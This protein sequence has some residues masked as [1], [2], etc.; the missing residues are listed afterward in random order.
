M[1][2]KLQIQKKRCSE[3]RSEHLNV[4]NS[5]LAFVSC[6]SCRQIYTTLSILIHVPQCAFLQKNGS[7]IRKRMIF[8][9]DRNFYSSPV[10]TR[11]GKH[12][13]HLSNSQKDHS[14]FPS[15]KQYK[16][17]SCFQHSNSPKHNPNQLYYRPN[18]QKPMP[19]NIY[20]NLESAWEDFVQKASLSSSPS[21]TYDRVPFLPSKSNIF[22]VL[23]INMNTPLET[24]R[25][26]LRRCMIRW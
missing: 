25:E 23:G 5:S 2:R 14:S 15:I 13:Y 21:I 20:E 19:I 3:A 18:E 7:G 1:T 4:I 6:R 12:G 16:Q 26:R 17:F 22:Q 9:S 10:L 8:T 11:L 24:K